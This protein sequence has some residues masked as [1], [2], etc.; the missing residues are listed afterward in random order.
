MTSCCVQN[1]ERAVDVGSDKFGG[2]CNRL[3]DVGFGGQM[4]D[5]TTSKFL[6]KF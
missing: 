2:V 5:P 6:E 3:I 4:H 1:R